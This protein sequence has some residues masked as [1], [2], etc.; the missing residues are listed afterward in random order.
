M[1]ACS[2]GKS[3]MV[4]IAVGLLVMTSTF[5]LAEAEMKTLKVGCI[6]PFT[7]PWGL[8]GV[9]LEPSIQIYA[10]LL[11][12][13]GG[14][15]I[16]EDTYKI[17]MIFVDDAG[18]PKRG[19]LAAQELL[20]KGAVANVGCFT[21]T[22]PIGA[23]LMP[24]KV[25]FVGQM[26]Q[27]F[28]LKTGRYFIGSNDEWGAPLYGVYA[29]LE[30]WP[31]AKNIGMLWYDWQKM[32][33]ELLTEKMLAP[34]N[35]VSD[36][37]IKEISR[38]YQVMGDMDYTTALTK[39]GKDG[40]DLI[41][42][43]I[44]PGDYAQACKQAAELGLKFHFFNAGTAT[45][46]DEFIK[47]AGYENAQGASY[48]WPCPWEIKKSQVDPEL[49]KMALRIKDRFKEKYGKPMTY[50]GGFDWGINHLR[51]LLDFYQQAGTLDPDKVM[52][53]VRGGTVK[54][55]T[56]TWKMGGEKTWGAP[57]VKGSACLDGVIK[58]NE[59]VYGAEYPMPTIP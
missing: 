5:G 10:D 46:L 9:A 12:E 8:Y 16:G 41:V 23:V 56:G 17:E 39:F 21:A 29:A 32:Q 4:A 33:S 6:M 28:D 59:V 25:L 57:V 20:R 27:S 51:I 2:L 40:V 35:P 44:G 54:D 53:K 38:H 26:Q 13:D 7:G 48:N 52:E 11:N 34:G 50:L 1:R 58:G 47:N 37:G 45:D 3:V 18:D 14:V 42:T 43:G 19:P 36:K 49:V 22:P 24:A 55:F 30:M 31:D 15:K